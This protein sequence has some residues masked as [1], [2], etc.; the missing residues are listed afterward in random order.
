MIKNN[1]GFTLIELLV[2]ISIIAILASIAVIFYNGIII[3]T[4]DSQRIRNLET[5]KQS[6]ELYRSDVHN[7]P[8]TADFILPG[9]SLSNGGV[10]YLSQSPTDSNAN[11][12]YYYQALPTDCDNLSTDTSCL[13]FILCA[14]K[15]GTDATYNLTAC[16]D[17]VCGSGSEKCDIGISSD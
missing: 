8:K 7:Y 13:S 15:E 3:K 4:R 12:K 14:K 10:T 11:R 16:G 2:A 17:F 5:I 6:L 9:G 1:S